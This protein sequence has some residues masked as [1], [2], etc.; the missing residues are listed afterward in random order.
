QSLWLVGRERPLPVYAEPEAW[1]F[2]ERLVD[3]YRPS[4]WTDAFPIEPHLLAR[5]DREGGDRPF[6]E[7][8]TLSFRAAPGQHAVPSVGLRVETAGGSALVYSCDT[9]PCPAITALA[10]DADLL[11]HE[12]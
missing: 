6:L 5:G 12:A 9:A 10:R 8:A 1:R 3:V 7:T 2:L 11:V 4:S